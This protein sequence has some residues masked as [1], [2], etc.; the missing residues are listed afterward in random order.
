[1]R[2][3]ILGHFKSIVDKKDGGWQASQPASI[4]SNHLKWVASGW[5]I[6][7]FF[8]HAGVG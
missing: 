5:E 4:F 3:L 1:M 6:P 8:I 7:L 2:K